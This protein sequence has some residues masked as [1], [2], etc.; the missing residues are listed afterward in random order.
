MKKNWR[1]QFN[2]GYTLPGKIEAKDGWPE[3]NF[4]FRPLT[5]R[6]YN[7]YSARHEFLWSRGDGGGC[8][9]LTIG[10]LEKKL[11]SWDITDGEPE[12]GKPAPPLPINQAS[13]TTLPD[14]V[15]NRIV[16]KVLAASQENHAKNSPSAS[17]S[18]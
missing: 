14:P 8:Y 13:L 15:F 3:I 18:N 7:D 9:D 17:G 4:T 6:E 5:P 10:L 12:E 2:D 1:H 11:A 16:G